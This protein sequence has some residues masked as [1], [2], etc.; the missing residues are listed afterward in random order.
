MWNHM[1]GGVTAP[2]LSCWTWTQKSIGLVRIARSGC[3]SARS[4]LLIVTV[5]GRG[6]GF[7]HC[8]FSAVHVA[9]ASVAS[10]RNGAVSRRQGFTGIDR[11]FRG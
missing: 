1:S 9:A 6:E 10:P 5:D 3:W 8:Q 7:A 2:S 4:E 11:G